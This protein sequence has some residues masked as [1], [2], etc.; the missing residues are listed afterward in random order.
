MPVLRFI[1]R[2]KL[3]RGFKSLFA[4]RLY[5]A[6]EFVNQL[7]LEA[8]LRDRVSFEQAGSFAAFRLARTLAPPAQGL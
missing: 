6:Q 3:Y 4:C 1:C 8:V 2:V 7:G 5:P